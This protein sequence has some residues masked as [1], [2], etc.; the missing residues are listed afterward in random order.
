[1]ASTRKLPV[2]EIFFPFWG[3]YCKVLSGSDTALIW[4]RPSNV[5]T[6][7][8]PCHSA[9]LTSVNDSRTAVS[10]LPFFVSP[11]LTSAIKQFNSLICW[12]FFAFTFFSLSVEFAHRL[13]HIW[14]KNTVWR[15]VT[16]DLRKGLHFCGS[17]PNPANCRLLLKAQSQ[18]SSMTTF[19][20]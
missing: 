6:H 11:S 12:G 9:F 2:I 4:G 10:S 18:T 17:R 3:L 20:R 16:L 8:L 1:M 19:A 5:A 7:E 14:L 15:Q 13:S